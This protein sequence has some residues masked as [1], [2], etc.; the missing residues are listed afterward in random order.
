[1]SILDLMCTDGFITVN[2]HICSVVGLEAAVVLGELASE[3]LYW[4]KNDPDFNGEFYSTV[5]NLEKRTFLTAHSQRLALNKL[6][7]NNLITIRKKGMPAKRFIR[8]NEDEITR[9]VNDLSLKS[10]TTG[11]EKSEAL[12]VQNFNGNNNR[13]NNNRLMINDKD[14]KKRKSFTPPTVDEV[15]EYCNQRGNNVNPKAFVAYYASQN[16]KKANGQP[17]KDWKQCVITWE[18]KDEEASSKP[19]KPLD[20]P[21]GELLKLEGYDE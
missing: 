20:D 12:V 1:M 16:W 6:Q 3:Y 9:V 18:I 10:L 2:R 11:D 15:T 21:F 13:D 7:D 5:E 19:A 14:S 17:V 4:Q 8:I